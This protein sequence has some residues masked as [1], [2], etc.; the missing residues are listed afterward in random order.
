MNKYLDQICVSHSMTKQAEAPAPKTEL[1]QTGTIA[2]TGIGTGLLAAKIGRAFPRIGAHN[3][4]M[5][6]VIGGLG[7]LGDYAAVKI[8]K[9]LEKTS[10]DNIYLERII[11]TY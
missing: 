6:G 3:G 8:N 11:E 1:M 4:K 5:A 7:L 9:R 10:S 2:A